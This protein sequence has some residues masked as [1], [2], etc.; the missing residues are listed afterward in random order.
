MQCASCGADI[1]L[2]STRC[3]YCGAT[4]A[5]VAAAVPAPPSR[6]MALGQVNASAH[7][8]RCGT[9]ERLAALPDRSVV[10]G[11]VPVVMLAVF[12]VLGLAAADAKALVPLV[13]FGLIIAAS[14]RKT[15]GYRQAPVWARAAVLVGKP[16][17]VAGGSGESGATTRYFLTAEC[18][19]ATR[20]EFEALTPD[21]YG[22]LV[23]G[24]AGVLFTRAAYALDFDRVV[25]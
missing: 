22:R 1:S 12:T 2:P 25:V 23:E 20:G 6:T 24:D 17:E 10:K 14:F 21:L 9:P 18:E 7:Y 8:A 5:P 4:H 11:W 15:R 13:I 19:D 3:E 16:T